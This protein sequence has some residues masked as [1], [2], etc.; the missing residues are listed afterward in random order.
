M[1]HIKVSNS[2]GQTQL[3]L[4]G[5][6]S[7]LLATY[8]RCKLSKVKQFYKIRPRSPPSFQKVVASSVYDIIGALT[9]DADGI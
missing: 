5:A 6:C 2:S 9:L 4:A 8:N 3:T 1:M 7:T